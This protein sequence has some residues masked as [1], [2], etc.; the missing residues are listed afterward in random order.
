MHT[1]DPISPIRLMND[2]LDT[3]AVTLDGETRAIKSRLVAQL[4]TP[5]PVAGLHTS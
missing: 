4:S 5:D 1:G 2:A 3:L